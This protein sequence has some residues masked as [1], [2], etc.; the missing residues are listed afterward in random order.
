MKIVPFI[1]YGATTGLHDSMHPIYKCT[2][3]SVHMNR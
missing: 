2:P 1:N 3:N